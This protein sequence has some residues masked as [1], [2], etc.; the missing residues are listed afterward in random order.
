[1]KKVLILL[2][3]FFIVVSCNKEENE[4]IESTY[5]K[6]V[7]YNIASYYLDKPLINVKYNDADK[8]SDPLDI[9]VVDYNLDGYDDV[10]ESNSH[11][12]TMRRNKFVFYLGQPDGSLKPDLKNTEKF[13]GL[14]HSRKGIVGDYN[15]DG[16]PDL[17]F[18]G[19]GYDQPPF[20]GEYPVLFLSTSNYS[21]EVEYF[22]EWV[23]FYHSASSGDL[24]ND[25]DLDI[26]IDGN[27]TVYFENKGNGVFTSVLIDDSS[28]FAKETLSFFED[29][30]T[31]EIIDLNND[32]YLDIILGGH[33]FQGRKEPN[34]IMYNSINGF[35][36][37]H[38]FI[39]TVEDY[40]TT[41]D[42]DFFDFNED[43]TLELILNRTG[44][45]DFYK[46]TY[47]QI[48]TADGKDITQDIF[49]DDSYISNAKWFPWLIIN[50]TKLITKSLYINKSWEI[51]NGNLKLN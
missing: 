25:G 29:K 21:F 47:I 40:Q 16:K 18:A 28:L 12:G 8:Y 23:D 41:I 48:V 24:D 33:E 34:V 5:I 11:Y 35:T 26:I 45:T 14:L 15:L 4:D 43:G 49:E 1:M 30:F 37:N 22:K 50:N 3:L 2:G 42:I 19:H 38:T 31:T 9:T 36:G 7:D 6:T 10:V 27:K 13:E 32:G 44:S 39:D 20:P 17:F 46:G 51:K